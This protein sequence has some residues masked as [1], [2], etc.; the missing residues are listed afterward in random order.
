[1]ELALISFEIF[2]SGVSNAEALYST[3]V[4]SVYVNI[5]RIFNIGCGFSI[6]WKKRGGGVSS[7]CR[8][9]RLPPRVLTYNKSNSYSCR[10]TFSAGGDYYFRVCFL[11]PA[12][13]S[14]RSFGSDS[15][16]VSNNSFFVSNYKNADFAASGHSVMPVC[17]FSVLTSSGENCAEH[18]NWS[19]NFQNVAEGFFS[20]V[21]GGYCSES[22]INEA[23]GVGSDSACWDI[24]TGTFFFGEF[25]APNGSEI[26]DFLMGR[27]PAKYFFK[28]F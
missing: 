17:Q 2:T 24:K 7:P 4:S 1:M 11:D 28:Y 14:N 6:A 25:N 13:A 27:T 8:Q 21:P 26:F 5:T 23:D 3:N 12:C 20:A 10:K 19:G 22:G 18:L 16:G 15:G 9:R